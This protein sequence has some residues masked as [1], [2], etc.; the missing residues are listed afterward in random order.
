MLAWR[1]LESRRAECLSRTEE[2]EKPSGHRL[3]GNLSCRSCARPP[4]S[5]GDSRLEGGPGRIRQ[6][7][8]HGERMGIQI[9][10]SGAKQIFRPD[11]TCKLRVI[12]IIRQCVADRLP[13][14]RHGGG[15]HGGLVFHVPPDLVEQV[16]EPF[17]NPA[18][19]SG[20]G[21]I[22]GRVPSVTS[23]SIVGPYGV[24]GAGDTP[25]RRRLFTCAPANLASQKV[26]MANGGVLVEEFDKLPSLGG[27]RELRFRIRL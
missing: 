1:L 23:V 11:Q 25:S 2:R 9:F 27:G 21:G 10:L 5:P 7:E 26:I 12:E 15:F 4:S 17:E 3:A 16:R 24:T 22:V 13:A 8:N 18:A 6:P 19:P 14:Q 20:T